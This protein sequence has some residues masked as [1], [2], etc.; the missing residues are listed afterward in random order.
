MASRQTESKSLPSHSSSS[1]PPRPSSQGPPLSPNQVPQSPSLT[2][3][4]HAA[5]APT[6]GLC[7][8]VCLSAPLAQLS[9]H[10]PSSTVRRH[11]LLLRLPRTH[12]STLLRVVRS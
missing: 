2:P 7:E 6:C 1:F 10:P 11:H 12:L 5:L 3:T 8:K 4:S 9:H